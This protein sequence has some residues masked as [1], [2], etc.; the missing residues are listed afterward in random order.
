M[1]STEEQFKNRFPLILL[2]AGIYLKLDLSGKCTWVY[3]CQE[4]H[5]NN[6]NNNNNNNKKINVHLTSKMKEMAQLISEPPVFP[7]SPV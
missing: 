3:F 5:N 2:G 1:I 7:H 6:N 4:C